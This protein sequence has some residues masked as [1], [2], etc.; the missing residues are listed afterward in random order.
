MWDFITSLLEIVDRANSLF[1][2]F[3]AFVAVIMVIAFHRKSGSK[4]RHFCDCADD[5]RTQYGRITLLRLWGPAWRELC[6][7]QVSIEELNSLL[8]AT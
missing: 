7:F 5:G 2:I 1:V 3:F 4:N 8:K 6:L